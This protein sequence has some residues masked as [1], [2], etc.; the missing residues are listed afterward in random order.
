MGRY[1]LDTDAVID[2]LNGVPSTVALIQTL[3]QQGDGLCTCDIV[4]AEVHAGLHPSERERGSELLASLRFL[5]TSPDAA[6]QAGVWRYD[7]ARRGRQLST[8]DCLIAAIARE[9]QTTL[10][11]GNITDYPMPDLNI[12]SLPRTR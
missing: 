4:T 8:T 12:L 3:Y 11:T 1:L 7:H 9:H 6:S 2:Y 5:P 10:V